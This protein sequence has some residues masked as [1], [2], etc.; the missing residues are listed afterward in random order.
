MS[1]WHEPHCGFGT[2]GCARAVPEGKVE[3]TVLAGSP[4]WQVAQAA[5]AFV[6]SWQR[7]HRA[8]PIVFFVTIPDLSRW[9]SSALTRR[10]ASGS[11]VGD[12]HPR[13]A[14]DGD[15]GDLRR[16]TRYAGVRSH[17][18]A[19]SP[20]CFGVR[21][22]EDEVLDPRDQVAAR[23]GDGAASFVA[24]HAL[25]VAMRIAERRGR[26]GAVLMA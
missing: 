7:R 14:V 23:P 3:P 21:R 16:V 10:A 19:V 25:Y 15:A 22:A 5:A 26:V 17:L 9:Q 12:S 11:L 2:S 24:P 20:R 18:P 8:M 13:G 4:V 1:E 6:P